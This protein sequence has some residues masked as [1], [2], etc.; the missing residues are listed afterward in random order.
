MAG[1]AVVVVAGIITLWLAISSEDGLV[2]DDYHRQELAINQTLAR[3]RAGAEMQIQ[4]QIS[5]SADNARIRLSLTGRSG[6]EL[7]RM[8]QLRLMHPTR[9]GKDQVVLLHASAPGLYQGRL[10][11]PEAGRWLLRLS[12]AGQTWR[13]SGE[14]RVPDE[15]MATLTAPPVNFR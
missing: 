9:T 7:P 3:E 6:A 10:S 14:W 13:V 2:E 5:F 4:A 8:A 12:D 1:P 11:A 15:K